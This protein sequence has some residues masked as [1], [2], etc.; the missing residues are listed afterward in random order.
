MRNFGNSRNLQHGYKVTRL[1]AKVAQVLQ[2][3]QNC[4][5]L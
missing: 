3:A 5:T 1:Q 2:V 4:I